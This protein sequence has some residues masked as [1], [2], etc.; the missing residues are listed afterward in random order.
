M[1]YWFLF[2]LLVPAWII[3]IFRYIRV[4]KNL[5]AFYGLRH[6]TNR[7]FKKYNYS[8]FIR[9]IFMS[10]AWICLV[11]ACGKPA[12]GTKAVPVEK[13]GSAVCFV[14][15]ISR[16]MLAKDV[17]ESFGETRMEAAANYTDLLL[18][19]LDKE[20]V[21]AV[22]AKGSGIIAVPL[23]ADFS[24]MY[25][26]TTNLSTN[27][28]SAPGSNL[29]A[30]IKAAVNSF[31][32]QSARNG[33]IILLTDGGETSGSLE[34]AALA[35]ARKGMNLVIV[36]FGSNEGDTII[37]GD[38]KTEVLSK[39]EKEKLQNVVTLVNQ[40]LPIQKKMVSYVDAF[41]KGAVTKILT[42]I[43]NVEI[44]SEKS[45]YEI[46]EI[47]RHGLFITLAIV[48][49]ILGIVF[50]EFKIS[51]VL[52][53]KNI[54]IM[55]ILCC[56]LFTSCNNI[57]VPWKIFEGR[58]AYSSHNYQKAVA[59]F[60]EAAE[61][62]DDKFKPYALYG[63]GTSYLGLGENIQ[64]VEKLSQIS[65]NAPEHILYGLNYNCGIAAYNQGHFDKAAEFFKNALLID[66]T[67]IDAK[68]NLEISKKQHSAAKDSVTEL[69]EV[70]EVTKQNVIENTIFSIIREGEEQRWKNQQV[71]DEI[72]SSQDY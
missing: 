66:G 15:D 41:E 28:M 5:G 26:L 52:G 11:I 71:T 12:W 64:C 32:S 40:R 42:T 46:Q 30:G 20:E 31:P 60:L 24:S 35:A 56:F 53:K 1:K 29:A 39:L 58:V 70:T 57:S 54:S 51:F 16:S 19:H 3:F 2:F 45:G 36:G 72:L 9:M 6:E 49:F 22:L 47:K 8:V 38:G 27:L 68:I 23:T 17:P 69:A 7:M 33:T 67:K 62:A 50:S 55:L 13:N 34:T 10:L 44:T 48:F 4:V 59:C 21:S 63:L 43:N 25:M 61:S 37:A 65:E 18:A 14:F